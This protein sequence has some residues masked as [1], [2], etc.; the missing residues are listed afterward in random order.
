[1]R[2]NSLPFHPHSQMDDSKV[3]SGDGNAVRL[4]SHATG[5][6]I[7]TLQVRPGVF[8]LVVPVCGTEFR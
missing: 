2:F 7:A 8:L 6:R 4:W 1:M 3:V 5:R